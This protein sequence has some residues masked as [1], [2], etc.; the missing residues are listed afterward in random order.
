MVKLG[1]W[2]CDSYRKNF[3]FNFQSPTPY[4]SSNKQC[5]LIK[6]QG[7]KEIFDKATGFRPRD[8]PWDTLSHEMYS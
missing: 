8:Q 2:G 5:T 7:K 1:C 3:V 4:F 6:L